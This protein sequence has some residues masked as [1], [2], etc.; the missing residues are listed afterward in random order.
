MRGAVTQQVGLVG[1][2]GTTRVMGWGVLSLFV[3]GV[4]GWR[5]GEEVERKVALS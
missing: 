2:E 1:T 5:A 3:L 4:V